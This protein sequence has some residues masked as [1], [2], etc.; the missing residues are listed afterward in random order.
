MIS[1]GL[2]DIYP[3]YLKFIVRGVTGMISLMQLK[4]HRIASMDFG[5]LTMQRMT[6]S[7]YMK[8]YIDYSHSWGEKNRLC[9]YG[10]YVINAN[11][12]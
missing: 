8:K 6:I 4:I 1:R 3:S 11:R 7:C 2:F 12:M 10:I 9:Y 5:K